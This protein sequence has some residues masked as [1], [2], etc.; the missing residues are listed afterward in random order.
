MASRAILIGLIAASAMAFEM[1][2]E[3]GVPQTHIGD[4]TVACN[5]ASAPKSTNGFTTN[6]HDDTYA[7]DKWNHKAKS[8]PD[9]FVA[10]NGVCGMK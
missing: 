9:C 3:V 8:L 1:E 7:C 4:A 10:I 5:P 6:F 2:Q